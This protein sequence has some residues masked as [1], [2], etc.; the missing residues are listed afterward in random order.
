MK[1]AFFKISWYFMIEMNLLTKISNNHSYFV[2]SQNHCPPVLYF[3]D[4]SF[5]TDMSL[6][7]KTIIKGDDITIYSNWRAITNNI[8]IS[9]VGFT[10]NICVCKYLLNKYIWRVF[11]N[12]RLSGCSILKIEWTRNTNL[13]QKILDKNNKFVDRENLKCASNACWKVFGKLW[14][15]SFQNNETDKKSLLFIRNFH[16]NNERYQ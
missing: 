2:L 10:T 4:N 15:F 1:I 12:N 5:R 6:A 9:N 13:I 11:H 8:Q 14:N 16:F 7:W 3:H